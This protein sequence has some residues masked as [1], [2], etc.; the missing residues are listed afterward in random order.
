MTY[1][2]L[3][4]LHKGQRGGWLAGD[5]QWGMTMTGPEWVGW[6][7][8]DARCCCCRTDDLLSF[9]RPMRNG[10]GN[11]PRVLFLFLCVCACPLAYV[12]NVPK[13]ACTMGRFKM[14]YGGTDWLLGTLTRELIFWPVIS[15]QPLLFF[16]LGSDPWT[17]VFVCRMFVF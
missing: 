17:N 15:D 4:T 3:C 5:G 7:T 1:Y 13:C 11:L 14:A 16:P 8:G 12:G 9:L 2:V 6:L 10:H